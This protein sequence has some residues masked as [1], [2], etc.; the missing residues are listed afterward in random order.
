MSYPIFLFKTSKI[1][2]YM[3]KYC[4]I[5]TFIVGSI[6]SALRLGVLLIRTVSNAN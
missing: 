1:I 5:L 6:R 3:N 2:F 4:V